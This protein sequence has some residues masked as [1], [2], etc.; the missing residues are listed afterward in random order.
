VRVYIDKE[1]GVTL[2]DCERVSRALS[3]VLDVEDPIHS[4]YV[5]EV[6]S[7]GLDRPLRRLEDFEE[8][9]GKLA[10]VVTGESIDGRT[11]FVGRITAVKN[12]DVRLALEGGKEIELPFE[13]VTKARLEIEF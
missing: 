12:G 8:N 10:R 5:L 2:D 11:F 13:Q 6:S 1:E 3:A 9:V 7:P 4:P